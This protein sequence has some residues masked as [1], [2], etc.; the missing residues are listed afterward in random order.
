MIKEYSLE[1]ARA[2]V[3]TRWSNRDLRRE[4]EAYLK[5][6]L[7]PGF[8]DEPRAVLWRHIATPDNGHFF[9]R[10]VARWLDV[11]PLRCDGHDKFVVMNR[12][13]RVLGALHLVFPDRSK[14]IVD[15]VD[16]RSQDG[17]LINEV[18]TKSGCLLMDLHYELMQR[19]DPSCKVADCS[20]WARRFRDVKE[21]YLR[22]LAHFIAHGVYLHDLMIDPFGYKKSETRF[23]EDVGFWAYDQIKAMFGLDP[24]TIRLYPETGQTAE[25][26]FYW[27]G[28]PREINDYLVGLVSDLGLDSRTVQPK[29]MDWASRANGS[30]ISK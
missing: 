10:S 7:L 12:D 17:K 1:E 11:R 20:T 8:N 6:D 26:D 23:V 19:F 16:F 29:A 21:V 14:R 3:R 22:L 18:V 9:F 30:G 2:E 15:L 13:K 28:F 5:D 24:V 27:L 25:E 4:V